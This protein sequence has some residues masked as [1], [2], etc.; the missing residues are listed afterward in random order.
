MSETQGQELPD[1]AEEH[2]VGVPQNETQTAPENAQA[3]QQETQQAELA[4]AAAEHQERVST[5]AT[6]T[7]ET[8]AENSGN[9]AAP[10]T[11]EVTESQTVR[12][13]TAG[14]SDQS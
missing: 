8:T 6:P 5:D 13:T 12:E 14:T 4:D 1:R 11:T 3:V 2:R 10:T 9:Q 7:Q